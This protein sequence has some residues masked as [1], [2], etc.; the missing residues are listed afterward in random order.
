V[1]LLAIA[2]L[3]ALWCAVSLRNQQLQDKAFKN[4]I[5]AP[6][7]AISQLDRATLLNAGSRPRLLKASAYWLAGGQK[8][9]LE[10]LDEIV[11]KHPEDRAAW[12][13]LAG[14]LH[15]FDPLGG[16]LAQRQVT[17]LDGNLQPK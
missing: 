14:I 16:A 13:A 4:V 9:A 7:L 5:T 3:A 1:L 15:R 2:A 17:E 10:Q 12:Q 11:N 6:T 8:Q